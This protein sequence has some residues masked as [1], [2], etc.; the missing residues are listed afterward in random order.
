[1]S[2]D[3]VSERARSVSRITD[4]RALRALAHPIRLSLL[5]LL[6]TKG[7]LTATRAGELLGESSASCSFHL[8]Q[9]AKYG[10]VEEAGGGHGRERPW[11]ATAT[12]TNIPE[13]GDDPE[14]AAAA[15][16]FWS[17]A[18]ERHFESATRWLDARLEEP[19]EWQAAAQF[20]DLLLFLTAPELEALSEGIR[21]LHE[22]YADRLTNP[23]L[24]PP[25]SRLV[26][27]IQLGFPLV[28]DPRATRGRGDADG[29]DAR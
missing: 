16:L 26:R 9:L 12:L 22:R 17:I 1:M 5:G 19:L 24:R 8:R 29:D 27:Y 18:L 25:G 28:D 10:L 6:R 23:A 4:P 13:V 20:N 11:R 14:L 15:H 21:A 2:G 3:E 7:P